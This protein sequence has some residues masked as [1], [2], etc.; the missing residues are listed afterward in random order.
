MGFLFLFYIAR[1]SVFLRPLGVIRE[2]FYGALLMENVP[3]RGRGTQSY[4][5]A[6]KPPQQQLSTKKLAKFCLVGTSAGWGF[7]EALMTIR[8][9]SL[10]HAFGWYLKFGFVVILPF[11]CQVSGSSKDLLRFFALQSS[12]LTRVRPCLLRTDALRPDTP[13]TAVLTIPHRFLD[14]CS[15]S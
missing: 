7:S 15:Q 12:F 2:T 4:S 13:L 1:N 8:K 6:L 10:E 3:P 14:R 11:R 5:C 9:R